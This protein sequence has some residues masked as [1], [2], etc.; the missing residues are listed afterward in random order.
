MAS[1]VLSCL[2]HNTHKM[3]KSVKKSFFTVTA[4][5]EPGIYS[6]YKD[7]VE[8]TRGYC[9][10]KFK[11]FDSY[12]AAL[13]FLHTTSCTVDKV[14]NESSVIKS[15]VG[16]YL[17]RGLRDLKDLEESKKEEQIE[18]SA[19]PVEVENCFPILATEF[20]EEVEQVIELR[21]EDL[22]IAKDVFPDIGREPVSP[23]AS[24][25][26]SERLKSGPQPRFNEELDL[27]EFERALWE[28]IRE[29]VVRSKEVKED[30]K[31]KRLD[32]KESDRNKGK[33]SSKQIK[34][35]QEKE[36]SR[37]NADSLMNN[38]V[39]VVYVDGCCLGQ[40]Q[41]QVL[42]DRRAGIGVF[43]GPGDERNIAERLWGDQTN[44]RAELWAAIRGVQSALEMGLEQVEVRTDSSYVVKGITS[45]IVTWRRNGYLTSTKK[46]VK[47]ADLFKLLD[48]LNQAMDITWVHV[49]GHCGIYGNENADN[50][51][52]LGATKYL[53]VT[54]SLETESS[55][56]RVAS[57]SSMS[58]VTVESKDDVS[59]GDDEKS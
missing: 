57:V 41:L 31:R 17:T 7:V 53:I 6:S 35:N 51:A 10:A 11:K 48:K 46:P 50:L 55:S 3:P 34:S 42:E 20:T 45:W 32:K 1:R 54:P 47:N 37:L 5:F 29:A 44:Q 33:L 2:R 30:R 52:K 23:S 49:A 22:F 59:S 39:P 43:W 4:G 38:G 13:A 24:V 27:I 58:E 9:N 8:Q 36:K 12:Q 25:R 56:T 14:A 28:H 40:N 21:E 26:K 19:G 15:Q 16:K 18:E